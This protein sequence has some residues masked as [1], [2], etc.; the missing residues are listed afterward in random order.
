ME[1]I[2]NHKGGIKISKRCGLHLPRL[3]FKIKDYLCNCLIIVH[4][5]SQRNSQPSHLKNLYSEEDVIFFGEQ[6]LVLFSQFS[7]FVDKV[8]EIVK[9]EE[10]DINQPIP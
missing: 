9:I 3:K 8:S 4:F 2:H 6:P 5:R 10:E 7:N 1:N